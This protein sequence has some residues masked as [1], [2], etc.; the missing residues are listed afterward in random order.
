MF[1][2]LALFLDHSYYSISAYIR[3]LISTPILEVGLRSHIEEMFIFKTFTLTQDRY[4]YFRQIAYTMTKFLYCITVESRDTLNEDCAA[5]N[6]HKHN[7]KNSPG[8]SLSLCLSGN[9]YIYMP[10]PNNNRDNLRDKIRFLFG[11]STSLITFINS[12]TD[13]SLD[14]CYD[15]EDV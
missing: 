15:R 1:C 8:L 7:H 4:I 10:Q 3:L 9:I 11:I 14:V 13:N 6:S 5:L 12:S 2:F